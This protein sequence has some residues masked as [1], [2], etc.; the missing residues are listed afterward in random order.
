M[1]L[2]PSDTVKLTWYVPK[3]GM[4]GTH[5]KVAVLVSAEGVIV[6][7]VPLCEY[8]KVFAG[9]SLSVDARE[10]VNPFSDSVG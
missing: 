6:P 3:S 2:V 10:T 4:V 9:M 5:T 1:P 8:V 7:D